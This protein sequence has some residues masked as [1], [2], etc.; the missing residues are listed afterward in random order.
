MST[1]KIFIAIAFAGLVADRIFKYFAI[2][3]PIYSEGFFLITD[4]LG[5]RY[6]L[7]QNFAGSLPLS[8]DLTA[9]LMAVVIIILFIVFI[10]KKNIPV[11]WLIIVGAIS[12]LFDRIAYSGV[13]DYIVVPWGGI[14]NIADVLVVSGLVVLIFCS[15]NSTKLV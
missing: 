7:N 2:K 12:N 4:K 6:H 5:L 9:A 3:S 1:Q 10:K 14:I 11:L 13:I 8:N 15:K